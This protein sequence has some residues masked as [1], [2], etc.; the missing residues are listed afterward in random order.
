M[1]HPFR[2]IE[3]KCKHLVN[4]GTW[5]SPDTPAT[6]VG[7]KEPL[8]PVASGYGY[9]GTVATDETENYIQCHICGYF[10]Q[11]LGNHLRTHDTNPREYRDEFGISGRTPLV[12][13]ALREKLLE[14]YEGDLI[15]HNHKDIIEVNFYKGAF[16]AIRSDRKQGSPLMSL[17]IDEWEVIGNIYS[18][19]GLMDPKQ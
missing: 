1:T 7:Y 2:T 18:N 17:G 14:V 8:D 10:L 12:G 9:Y 5:L 15:T 19:P 4:V 11:Q 6:Y 3:K 16:S 13:K